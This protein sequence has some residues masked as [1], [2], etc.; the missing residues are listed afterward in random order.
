MRNEGRQ[1]IKNE[2]KM[3]PEGTRRARNQGQEASGAPLGAMWA[4]SGRQERFN[5]LLV[6]VRGGPEGEKNFSEPSWALL[7]R[8]WSLLLRSWSRKH[9]N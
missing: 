5:S 8:F 7:D 4:Q 1:I 3:L 2:R 9:A 6:T